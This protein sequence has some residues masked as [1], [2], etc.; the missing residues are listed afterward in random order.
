MTKD[1]SAPVVIDPLPNHR[2]DE[3]ALALWLQPVLQDPTQGMKI[4]QFQGGMSNPTFLLTLCSGARLILRK[5]PPGPLLPKAHAVDREFRVMQALGPTSVPVPDM[6]AFCDDENIIGAEF[7]VME[8]VPGRIVAPPSMG[9]IARADRPA[10]A[11]SL[12]DT[13][14]DLHL[15]DWQAVGLTGFG[16]PEG[17][18]A[19]QTARWSAQYEAAKPALPADFDY[20]HMDW[21]RDWLMERAGD[22]AERSTIAHGDYRM[23]NTVVHP[24]EPR[25]AAVLD[26]EL[27]TIG[28]PFA[29]L[30][31][32]LLHYRL[33]LDLPD[34]QDMAAAGLPGEAQMLDRY[35]DRVGCNG[36]P[37]WPLFL[38]F[39]CFRSAAIGQGVAARAMQGNVS[40][41]SADAALTGWRAQK[42]AE[43]GA[44]IARKMDRG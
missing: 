19:R 39:A 33:P 11:Y 35:C 4:Q 44:E 12:I 42:V 13:L 7:F 3:A 18:M 2:F 24:T 8:Y 15:V 22:I 10:L 1:S 5:K 29:D 36:I 32:L 14:A 21:L 23:G 6:L 16:R 27:S 28:H 37:D 17:Y 38:A 26:W 43:C 20:T 30:A 25:I 34:V 41:A 31:Y 9:P 40:T